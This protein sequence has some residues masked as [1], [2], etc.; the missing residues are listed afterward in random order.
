MAV[1]S[2]MNLECLFVYGTL[3]R[4][5]G[6]P[7]AE[8]LADHGDFIGAAC[9][10]GRLF[11]IDYY[12]GLVPSEDPSHQVK[13][14]VYALRDPAGLLPRLDE[15]EECGPGFPEPAEYVREWRTVVLMDGRVL[16]AW[17]YIYNRDTEILPEI[18]SGDFLAHAKLNQPR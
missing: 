16:S 5:A 14:D 10:Q 12:P 1:Q 17:V 2:D 8:L 15:Y 9:C 6:H 7:M 13:G 3:R 4:G 18:A 11:H